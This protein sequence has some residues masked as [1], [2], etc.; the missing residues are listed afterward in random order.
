MRK[1]IR[2]TYKRKLKISG[3]LLIIAGVL[4][5]VVTLV[6]SWM[7][8]LNLSNLDKIKASGNSEAG[9]NQLNPNS[10]II[11]EF[12]WEKDPVTHSTLGPDAISA[13][14][15]SHCVSGGRSFT[16]G[17][18]AGS[19]GKDIDLVIASS[20]VYDQDGI[21][22]SIDFRR[23]ETSGNFFTRGS[24]FNFGM[25]K[26]FITISYRVDNKKGGY[27]TVSCLTDYEIPSDEN[28]R[29]YRFMYDPSKGKGEIF[30]N[31]II[32][33]S[34]TATP[35]TAMHWKGAGN[36]VIGKDM[37][38]GGRDLAVFDNLVVR[39]T[40]SLTPLEESLMNFMVETT[41]GNGVRL[42]WSTVVNDRVESFALQRSINGIDF[43]TIAT[44]RANPKMTPDDEYVYVDQ[45]QSEEPIYYY[46]LR[47][48]FKD[49]KF[50]VHPL[51]AIKF[52]SEKD[53]SIERVNP[54]PF[55]K[56]FDISYFTPANG[57][58][59]IQITDASGKV[60]SSETFEA[61][62]GKNVHVF[63]NKNP[64]ESGTYTLNLIF[65][66]KKVSTTVIKI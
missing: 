20:P 30:V 42:H 26:G 16:H 62:R 18:S 54:M 52:D 48:N 57:R 5:I 56:T 3:R 58:V 53:L 32:V 35:N 6:I 45:P 43:A 12:T 17:L 7:V 39:S 36:I 1:R 61:P 23:F 47:Q 66:E 13:G 10:E 50:M 29:N 55:E 2:Q 9:G 65:G 51:A 37:D 33:W 28:F 44:V 59:W 25:N 63:K 41:T 49:G 31:N 14:K 27:E 24:T 21:D 60:R 19:S 22:I 15:S 40:V 46:R 4:S 38:G 11:S 64:L 8:Y 34:S